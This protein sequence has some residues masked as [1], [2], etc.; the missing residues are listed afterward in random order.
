MGLLDRAL[1]HLGA[2]YPADHDFW[3]GAAPMA[4]AS[5]VGLSPEGAQRV[6]AFYR[7]VD[8]LSTALAMLPL[9]MY[10]RLPD[11]QGADVARQHPVHD[12]LH[13]KPNRWQDSFRYRRQAMRHLLFRGN[14]YSL[15][16]PGAR[17]FADQLWPLSPD[18][19]KPE[20]KSNG[21][22]VYHVRQKDGQ[23]KTYLQ[24]EIF[25]LC[26]PS[27]DGVE[28]V[29]VV[30][31]ARDSLGLAIATEGYA[32]RLFSQG[33]LYGTVVEVP[34]KPDDETRAGIRR[35]MQDATSG[36]SN[37][38]AALVTW[39]GM[40]V[41]RVALTGEESQFI[42]SRKF[43]IDDIARWLGVPPHM[44]GSLERSTN[45]NIEHQ[46]TE[47]VTYSLGPWLSLWEQGINDQLILAP[48]SYYAE[49]T[50]DALVR[51]DIATRWAAYQIAVSTGTY[52]RNE[53][54]RLENRKALAGLDEP[55]N[56]AHLTGNTTAPQAPPRQA[57][58]APATPPDTR[59]QAIAMAAATRILRKE[60]AAI[61]KATARHGDGTDAWVGEVSEF[62]AKHAPFVAQVMVLGDE[63]AETYCREQLAA[64][65]TAGAQ[66]AATC[67]DPTLAAWLV[68][69][70]FEEEA[71]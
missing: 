16:V 31:W 63:A 5:G 68:G 2:S 55:I 21:E 7:G 35:S 67:E 15:I 49:F 24:S 36:L 10:R 58:P 4:T 47:F 29:G 1:G 6:S 33:S 30:S 64:A 59:G 43:S 34:T 37:A 41:E 65:L 45:N 20:L 38:H 9:N 42:A 13:R 51:G 22:V 48:Q 70:A 50:R 44:I 8:L 17:G 14:A 11:E 71:A 40:K 26:G 62:Y 60:A 54:R 12:L 52:T 25:H 57:R 27:D 61:A 56:P 18:T 69:L 46:G 39:A 66:A 32:A 19:V 3:Y 23:R 53:V 28:G